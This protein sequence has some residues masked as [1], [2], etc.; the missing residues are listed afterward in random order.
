MRRVLLAG[1]LGG[2]MGATADSRSV[3]LNGTD[4]S[5]ARDQTLKHVDLHIDDAGNIFVTAPQYQ[6]HEE[7]S[8]FPIGR[9][10]KKNIEHHSP[11]ELPNASSMKKPAEGASDVTKSDDLM[12]VPAATPAPKDV[13]AAPAAS[14]TPKEIDSAPASEASGNKGGVT[15]GK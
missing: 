2:A 7:S 10:T 3:Y 14:S 11:K 9:T 12:G 8:F 15:G 1:V 4:F 6:V 5:N 13:S